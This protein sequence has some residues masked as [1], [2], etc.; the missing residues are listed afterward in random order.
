MHGL[1]TFA[2][3]LLALACCVRW[4]SAVVTEQ[5]LVQSPPVWKGVRPADRLMA[6]LY[7]AFWI[8]FLFSVQAG[9]LLL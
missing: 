2:A 9:R 8:W 1:L 7:L 6:V 3:I 5:P 4:L